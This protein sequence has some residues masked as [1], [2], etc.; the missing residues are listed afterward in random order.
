MAMVTLIF[1]ASGASL[2]VVTSSVIYQVHA[3]VVVVSLLEV[4]VGE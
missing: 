4:K 2:C 3:L 1:T